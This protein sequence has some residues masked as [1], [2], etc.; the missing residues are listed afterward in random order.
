MIREIGRLTRREKRG[1][2]THDNG[3][4]EKNPAR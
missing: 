4:D 1:N 3:V 2:S